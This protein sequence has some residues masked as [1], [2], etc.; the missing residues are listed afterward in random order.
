MALATLRRQV[1]ELR[2]A[3]S[4][5][6]GAGPLWSPLPGPQTLALESKADVLGYGGA[7]GGGKTDL[8]LGLA[9]TQHL[10]SL[11]LRREVK[12]TRAVVERA[13]ELLGGIGR[14]NENSGV[15]RGIPGG[16]ILEFGGCKDPGDEQHY[17]GRPHDFLCFDEADQFPEFMVRFISGWLRTTVK[18]QRC[19]LLLCFNPPSSAE[20]DWLLNFFGPWVDDRHPRPARPGELRW[21]AVTKDG[22]E[23]ERPDGSPFEQGGE[24]VTPRSRTFIPARLLDNPHL[25]ATGYGATLQALPEPL[26]SQLLYGDF[27][28]GRTDDIWQVIPTAWVKAAQARWA[29]TPPA[30]EP[31]ACLGVDCA[32]GGADQTVIAPRHGAWFGRLRKYRGQ[33]TDSGQKAA[34]LVLKEHRDGAAVNVDA[35]GYGSACYEA[36]RDRIG[37]LA[38]AVNAA[39]PTELRDRSKKFKLANVR[40][41]MYWKLR[42]ALDPVTGDN[43]ALPPDSELL[44]DLTALRY[45]VRASGLVIESKEAIKE[46]LGRSPDCG[47]SVALAHWIG[48][49]KII[50]GV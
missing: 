25:L 26:R 38:V 40:A 1:A 34:Y 14:F 4:C 12:N 50:F 27:S 20:G 29:E 42:E 10:C 32:Y 33:A 11:I 18:G 36:L 2:R 43:L 28:I 47:D 5:Y 41:A 16:R 13:R 3:L 8:A 48:K 7:S 35:V 22:E 49:R 37:P 39:A 31:L 44:G 6:G 17:R 21:Y 24:V 19:R 46:R 9:L 15:W 23:V 45:E 30:G